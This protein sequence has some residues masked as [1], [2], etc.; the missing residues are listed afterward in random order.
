MS[1]DNKQTKALQMKASQ[2]TGELFDLPTYL[3]DQPQALSD[4]LDEISKAGEVAL[5]TEANS[6][7]VYQERIC[8]VQISTGKKIYIFDPVR[9]KEMSPLNCI[10]SDPKI[11]KYIHGADY[12]VGGLKR[13][14]QLEF[15]NIF[16]TM[17]AAQFTN[18]PRIG[19]ADLVEHF[20]NVHLEKKFTK[21]NWGERPISVQQM[22]YLCKDVQY[23]ID[24]GRL[25]RQKLEEADLV[26]E[27]ELEFR[28]LESRQSME[29]VRNLR[30]IWAM[31]GVRG[32]SPMALSVMYELYLWREKRAERINIPPFKIIN[33]KTMMEIAE[34]K[35]RDKNQLLT[36]KGITHT[37]YN[38]CGHDL[39]R[40]VR[41]GL[42]SR[43]DR[44]PLPEKKKGRRSV[45]WEDQELVDVLKKYRQAEAAKREIHHLAV[46]PGQTL[47][48]IARI[49]PHTP[50]DLLAIDG[51]GLKRLKLYG[52]DVLK[53]LKQ[54]GGK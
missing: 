39:L 3:I 14:F 44:I 2:I 23:L 45:H 26:E 16:D 4:A 37:V 38:R 6:L 41:K 32:L 9:L 29:P 17:V 30:N 51:F 27:A 42:T 35:P 22:I 31:K 10:T 47:E 15:T 49:K 5:D 19:M 21:S 11:I 50:E 34:A 24:L 18:F 46:L 52:E 54:Q 7:Y 40:C 12:D 36:I 25:L 8:V 48:E 43:V 1:V 28:R 20:F 13:D 33:N 53:I